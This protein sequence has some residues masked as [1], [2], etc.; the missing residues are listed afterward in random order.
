MIQPL[1]KS[2]CQRNSPLL[3]CL[4]GQAG[5]RR[6]FRASATRMA[7]GLSKS[8]FPWKRKRRRLRR[9]GFE[10][11]FRQFNGNPPADYYRFLNGDIPEPDWNALFPI[12]W[13]RACLET[14]RLELGLPTAVQEI[15]ARLAQITRS[16][17]GNVIL[18]GGPPC[19][20][21]S[22][23]GRARNKGIEGYE[24][25]KDHRHFLY[26]EYIRILQTLM[27]AAL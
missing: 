16:H 1:E 7:R 21:Y 15:D 18:I 26:K 6:A 25:S 19:Q 23:V 17:R 3:T 24:A 4:Q 20:A 5:W 12:E 10:A 13:A 11:F 9:F 27:P 14:V 22:L 8:P 2:K